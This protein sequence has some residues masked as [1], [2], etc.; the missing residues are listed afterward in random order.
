M[1]TYRFYLAPR[2]G[3][4]TRQDPLR[5]KLANYIINDGTMDFWNW[6]NRATAVTINMAW[7]ESSLHATIDADAE[8]R[9][10]SP[11][12][13]DVAAVDA[14]LDGLIGTLPTALSNAFEN[15]GM[16]VHW[17]TGS[18]TR[19][20]FMRFL[21]GWTWMVQNMTD[22]ERTF[23]ANNLDDTMNQIG[24]TARNRMRAWMEGK[25]L[26]TSWVVNSTTVRAVVVFIVQNGNYPLLS[27]GPV[28][29]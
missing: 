13:A 17:I 16:P 3:T 5:S 4:G 23:V 7:C 29:F 6:V 14:W 28:T 26:D 8:I 18:T 2:L 1:A 24:A 12:L 9:A 21:A 25:G 10:I 15:A 22:Q 19:R 20:Q 11:E 27:F